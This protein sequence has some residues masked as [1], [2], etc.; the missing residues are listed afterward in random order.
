MLL[1]RA[2]ISLVI[3][4]PPLRNLSRNGRNFLNVCFRDKL[5]IRTLPKTLHLECGANGCGA[6]RLLGLHVR[7]DQRANSWSV[8]YCTATLKSHSSQQA[9]NSFT[10]LRTHLV[11]SASPQHSNGSPSHLSCDHRRFL[12]AAIINDKMKVIIDS[13]KWK[14]L[15]EG[16][17]QM[18]IFDSTQRKNLRQDNA[19]LFQ[20]G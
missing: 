2:T 17:G 3:K 6:H 19:S 18:R 1:L 14:K 20:I 5:K 12:N 7:W 16:C 8:D 10:N 4:L 9:T 15:V 13:S 11:I